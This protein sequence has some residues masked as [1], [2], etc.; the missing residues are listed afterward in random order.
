MIS[1][2][3]N[4]LLAT[5]YAATKAA[6]IALATMPVTFVERAAALMNIGVHR[7]RLSNDKGPGRPSNVTT[8]PWW[9]RT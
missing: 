4:D 3:N 2:F 1:L 8:T 7:V 5:W 9:I 6:T